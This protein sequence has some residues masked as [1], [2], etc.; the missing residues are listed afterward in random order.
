MVN[1][2][3]YKLLNSRCAILL[4][5][6]ANFKCNILISKAPLESQSQGSSLCT[7]AASNQRGCSEDSPWE[8]QV[9]PWEVQ[10]RFPE[11]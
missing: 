2:N 3:N 5:T 8:V 4:T 10:V 1:T 7:S 6:F 9:R 11:T